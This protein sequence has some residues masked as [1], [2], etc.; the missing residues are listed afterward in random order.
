MGK[1]HVVDQ[2]LVNPADP[3]EAE[4]VAH[5]YA[6][7]ENKDARFYNQ[8]LRKV[9]VMQCV[10]AALNGGT[11]TILMTLG[12]DL[13]VTWNKVAEVTQMLK[14]NAEKAASVSNGSVL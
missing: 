14:A 12:M 1:W 8:A 6:R 10:Q 2:I 9:S 11:N 13:A 4:Q 3:S 7:E 5:K